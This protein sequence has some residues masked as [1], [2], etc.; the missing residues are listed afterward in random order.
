MDKT[1]S[2]NNQEVLPGQ[3]KTIELV[4]ARLYDFTELTLPIHIIRGKTDGPTL[5]LSGAIHGDELVG[6]AIIK[7]IIHDRRLRSISGTLVAVPIVN[8][9]GFNNK[10]RYLP[11]R[12]DLNRCFPGSETGSLAS[13][14][15]HLFMKE[16]VEKCQYGIDYHSGA[17]HRSNLPQVRTVAE[18]PENRKLAEAF[19]APVI[20][21][22]KLREGSIRQAAAGIGIRVVLFEGGEA[23]RLDEK[24]IKLGVNGAFSVMGKIGMLPESSNLPERQAY[25]AKS[26]YWIRAAQSGMIRFKKG[27]GSRVKTGSTL[28]TISDTF[29]Q[30]SVKITSPT[31]GIIIGQTKL[32]LVNKGDA[33]FHIATFEDS[34]MVREL[35]ETLSD[36]VLFSTP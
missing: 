1:F 29:G 15:A 6:P 22:S 8:V 31:S 16:V 26:N 18:H 4:L 25:F 13:R 17:I 14:I 35:E 30:H 10:S 34:E 3:R 20:L 28:G 24:V 23:L 7:Q 19:G 32:P 33:L 21:D 36:D 12:R 9:F 11:D 27:L 5:F 2:I